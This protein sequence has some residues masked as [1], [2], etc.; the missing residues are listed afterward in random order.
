MR[1]I[2]LTEEYITRIVAGSDPQPGGSLRESAVALGAF[3]GLHRGHQRLISAVLAAKR[4]RRLQNSCLFTFRRHPRLVLDP[5]NPPRLLTTWRE[6]V[7]LLQEAGLDAVVAADF[8]PALAGLDYDVFVRRFLV[9]FLGMR[10][11]VAGHD[12]H[13]GRGRGG[14]ADTLAVLGRELGF[15]LEIVPP[16][17][18]DGRIASS[19]EIRRELDAGNLEGAAALLGRAYS[20]WGEV[21][22]GDGRGGTIGYPTANISPLDALK[23]LPAPGVYA[24]RVQV[25]GDAVQPDGAAG[26]IAMVEENLPEVDRR[27]D[28]LGSAAAEWA[29][30]HGML[31]F[32][33]APTFRDPAAFA[34]RIEAHLFGFAGD[35][36][37]RTVKVEWLARLRDERK[38]GG[39]QELMAQLARDATAAREALRRSVRQA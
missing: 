8:C 20:L 21:V 3:D 18:H 22:P 37:G 32:G 14:N 31:N 19:S 25:P 27:G 29:I 35:L 28:L 33:R 2:R 34:A 6:K 23:A 13:L 9:E 39:V 1:L 12:V 15:E 4:A 38:F 7:A 16:L 11:F 30:F 36:R 26:V 10:H 5:G 17:M 24:V